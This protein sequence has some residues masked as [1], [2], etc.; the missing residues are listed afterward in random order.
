MRK[1]PVKSGATIAKGPSN[2]LESTHD[3]AHDAAEPE[4]RPSN[5][6][7]PTYFYLTTCPR[8]WFKLTDDEYA[9]WEKTK[10]TSAWYSKPRFDGPFAMWKA[11]QTESACGTACYMPIVAG[12]KLLHVSHEDC[13]S[14]VGM[15]WKCIKFPSVGSVIGE[16][17][18]AK[19]CK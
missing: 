18:A 3:A 6:P 2:R 15:F 9:D 12:S 5:Q 19:L 7:Y 17:V 4:C 10:D 14:G 1:G 16:E 8:M 11:P 13:G